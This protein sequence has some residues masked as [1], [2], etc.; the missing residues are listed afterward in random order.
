M[1][2]LTRKVGEQILIDERILI[3]VVRTRTGSVR[4]GIEAP[5]EVR[6]SRIDP[7][8]EDEPCAPK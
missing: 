2:V 8:Q 7:P 6:I 3:T 1:L 5:Q 4:L